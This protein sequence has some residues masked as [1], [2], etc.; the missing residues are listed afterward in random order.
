[1]NMYKPEWAE[2]D[3]QRVM[4]MDS[5]YTLDERHRPEHPMHGLYTG[6]HQETLIAE[7]WMKQI[8]G[9]E[10]LLPSNSCKK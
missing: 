9:M 7:K 2:E 8:E 10:H 3:R 4:R 1:M 6:L 5:L